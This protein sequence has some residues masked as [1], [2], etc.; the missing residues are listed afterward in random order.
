MS[1]R[2]SCTRYSV[3]F[4][5]Y[6]NIKCPS[7]CHFSASCLARQMPDSSGMPPAALAA[8]IGGAVG[9]LLLVLI[10][11]RCRSQRGIGLL[12]ILCLCP[13]RVLGEWMAL[14][15]V[16]GNAAPSGARG[17]FEMPKWRP[18]RLDHHDIAMSHG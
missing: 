1:T 4:L 18:W 15:S 6:Q 16:D 2:Y 14:L 7:L 17:A 5:R 3:Q 8:L 13:G 11:L 10:D 9:L 12:G